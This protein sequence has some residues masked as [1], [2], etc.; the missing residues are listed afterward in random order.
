LING[1]DPFVAVNE[2]AKITGGYQSFATRQNSSVT[3]LLRSPSAPINKSL[4]SFLVIQ[5][6]LKG[7]ITLWGTLP[8]IRTLSLTLSSLQYGV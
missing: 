8:S 5:E 4:D 1:R 2:N 3:F 6:G 7:G